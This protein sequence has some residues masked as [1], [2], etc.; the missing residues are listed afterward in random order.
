MCFRC[1]E[2]CTIDSAVAGRV[3]G[4]L[5]GSGFADSFCFESLLLESDMSIEE[6]AKRAYEIISENLKE[7]SE[8]IKRTGDR[9]TVVLGATITGFGLIVKLDDSK[10]TGLALGLLCFS[11]FCLVCTFVAA[12]VGLFPKKGEQPGSTDVDSIWA[13][14][15]AVAPEIAFANSINDL[16]RVIRQRRDLNIKMNWWFRIT[17]IFAVLTLSCCAISEAVASM[18]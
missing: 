3:M 9:M 1:S 11:I 5:G 15:V 7:V 12:I 4:A 14:L 8:M 6:N 18:K 17:L 10:S 16:C 13:D 2:F